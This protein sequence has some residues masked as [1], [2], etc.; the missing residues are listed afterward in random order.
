MDKQ[1]LIDLKAKVEAGDLHKQKHGGM[2]YATRCY[3]RDES[4][5]YITSKWSD[6]GVM[7]AYHG[8][9]D[10]ALSL[11]EAVL[12]GWGY[13]FDN[14]DAADEKWATVATGPMEYSRCQNKI[15]SRALLLAI[16]EALI[17]QA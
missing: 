9:V 1:A 15:H 5:R 13:S 8:S 11:L 4:G 6:A 14:L 16:L 10:A 12:P 3:P 7:S 17:S 2:P